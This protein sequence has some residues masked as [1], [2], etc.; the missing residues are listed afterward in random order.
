VYL[1]APVG[2]GNF[3]ARWTGRLDPPSSGAYHIAFVS[4]DGVRLWLD[5]KLVVENW[6]DHAPA[7][8]QA[9]VDLT[10]GRQV[11]L[12]VEYYQGGGGATARLKWTRPDDTTEVIPADR[13]RPPDGHGPGLRAE[14]FE[15]RALDAP[16][17][18]R[19]DP[20]IDFEWPPAPRPVAR[21]TVPGT[22]DVGIELPAGRYRAEWTIPETGARA[23]AEEFDHRGGRRRLA[24][25]PFADDMALAIRAR[26]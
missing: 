6:S 17:T 23:K 12:K 14:Y 24:S 8:D 22:V 13:L 3:A 5:G 21:K 7:E 9:T 1:H 19:I 15:G 16:A 25:P 26:P 18:V 11:D 20:T 10:E 4:D 2:E